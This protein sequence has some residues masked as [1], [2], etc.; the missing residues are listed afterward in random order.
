MIL[1]MFEDLGPNIKKP[2][3]Q[4]Y[5][6]PSKHYLQLPNEFKFVFAVKFSIDMRF[7][8]IFRKFIFLKPLT[9]LYLQP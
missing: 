3:F 5:Q 1:S 4:S 7:E 2:K 8:N 9:L 6:I